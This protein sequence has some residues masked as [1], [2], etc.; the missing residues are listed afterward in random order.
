M[1]KKITYQ[2]VCG[3]NRKHVRFN[4]G[5]DNLPKS[6]I[7]SVKAFRQDCANKWNVPVSEIKVTRVVET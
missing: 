3:I 7:V 2:F 4:G 1:S 6:G 5:K